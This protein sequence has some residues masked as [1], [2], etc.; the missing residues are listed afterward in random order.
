MT[1]IDR[2][3]LCGCHTVRITQFTPQGEDELCAKIRCGGCGVEITKGSLKLALA[4]WNGK[5]MDLST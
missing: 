3:K 2:C 4:A 5:Q 1:E